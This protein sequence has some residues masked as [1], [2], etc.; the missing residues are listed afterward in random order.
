V[1]RHE[2]SRGVVIAVL[3]TGVRFDHPDLGRWE[4]GGRL[5]PGYDLVSTDSG[6]QA[7][8][9]N[10]G[11]GWDADPSDPGDWISETDRQ[12]SLFSNCEVDESSWHGT[13]VAGMIGAATNNSIGVAGTTWSA[14][15]LPVRV[16]GKCGGYTSDII[17]GMRWAA[18]LTLSGVPTNPYPAKILNLSLGGDGECSAA[19]QSA[20]DEIIAR[21][22]LVIVSAGND[23][24]TVDAPA[25]CRGVAAIGALRHVGNKVG[26][27]NLGT[28]VAISAPG[29]N[30]VNVGQGQPCLFSLDTT[31]NLGTTGPGAND[32]TNQTRFN[33]GTSFSAPI[34]AGIAGLM[35][36]VNGNLTPSQAIARLR[37]AARPFPVVD[38]I[39]PITGQPIPTC[40]VPTS[41]ADTQLSQCN[42]TTATCGAGIADAPGAVTQALRPIAAV[43]LPTGAAAGQQVTLNAVGSGAAC[44]RTVTAYAWSVVAGDVAPTATAGPQTSV[45]VPPT[46][47]VV[48][49]TVTD[50]QGRTDTADVTVGPGVLQSNAPASAGSSACLAA[51]SPPAP[52]PPPA[53]GGGPTPPASGGGGG[54]GGALDVGTL[55]LAGA[56]ALLAGWG[57]RRSARRPAA[58]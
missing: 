26:F 40:R 31:T 29:G 48:R 14:W 43:T 20:I 4:S 35:Y 36:A 55:A 54:G 3:D 9:A 33:V 53:P 30:C 13:R 39:D 24:S 5:L 46:T 44:G 56:V 15:L 23:G 19:Y 58:R 42:C 50:D 16:L 2:G 25:N 21:G 38:E 27:S 47:A 37:T 28:N 45:T 12:Q 51:L 1:G 10:D 57:R 49:L 6:G 8:T 18:G 11:D 7:L 41:S 52:E 17:A 34:V 32:Y 22:T